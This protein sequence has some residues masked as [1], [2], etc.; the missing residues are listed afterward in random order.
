MQSSLGQRAENRH[1][2]LGVTELNIVG[3]HS[4]RGCSRCSK[5]PAAAPVNGGFSLDMALT[6]YFDPLLLYTVSV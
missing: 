1:N 5:R 6:D 2:E 3:L 4:A